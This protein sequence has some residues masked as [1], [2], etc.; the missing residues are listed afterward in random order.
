MNTEKYT[1]KF[2]KKLDTYLLKN[3]PAIWSSRIHFVLFYTTLLSVIFFFVLLL[4]NKDP[5]ENSSE[6]TWIILLSIIIIISIVLFIIYLFRFNVMK[7]FGNWNSK[8]SLLSF[9][10]LFITF[11]LIY[12]L[13]N[14]CLIFLKI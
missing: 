6:F 8:D 2:L 3:K 7:R 14:R 1:P 9:V 4:I 11:S 13:V 12:F 10:F 5:R